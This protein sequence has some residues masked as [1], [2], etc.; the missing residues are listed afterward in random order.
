MIWRDKLR[1]AKISCEKHR[2]AQNNESDNTFYSLVQLKYKEDFIA[3]NDTLQG[4]P[5][6]LAG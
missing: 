5:K 2:G 1:K 3:P 6:T 4:I